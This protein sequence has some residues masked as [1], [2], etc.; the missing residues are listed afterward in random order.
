MMWSKAELENLALG[1]A[2]VAAE[3]VMKHLSRPENADIFAAENFSYLWGALG[4]AGLR[5]T[6]AAA[7][8]KIWQ[9]LKENGVP[10]AFEKGI[11]GDFTRELA[12]RHKDNRLRAWHGLDNFQAGIKFQKTILEKL[13]KYDKE[14]EEDVLPYCFDYKKLIDELNVKELGGR[15][16]AYLERLRGQ[17][18]ACGISGDAV[19]AVYEKRAALRRLCDVAAYTQRRLSEAEK[20]YLFR[21][22]REAAADGFAPQG[23][24]LDAQEKADYDRWQE[25]RGDWQKQLEAAQ[26]AY[27]DAGSQ[28]QKLYQT[29]LAHFSDKAEQERKLSASGVRLTDSGDT[30]SR[31]ES[32][33]STA[34]E[35]LQRA[36]VNYLKRGN[37]DLA[38]ALAAQYTARMTP[39]QPQRFEKLLGQYGMTLA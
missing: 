9:V 28:D 17:G 26:A 37:G 22:L 36:V 13:A 34:A 2:E 15:L 25:A 1:G 10:D 29:L 8:R 18:A 30:G 4:V 23:I 3:R 27:E 32:L 16:K 11:L 12:A 14:L 19:T 6:D 5:G 33:S 35:S 39:A 38:Q 31:G 21:Y 24:G 7:R 20:D